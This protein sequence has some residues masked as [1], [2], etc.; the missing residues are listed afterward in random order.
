MSSRAAT[1]RPAG[2]LMRDLSDQSG[3]T[4]LEMALVLPSF[5]LLLFGLFEF[6][7]VLFGYCSA[8]YVSG[9]TARY[10]AVHSSTSLAP[11]TTASL[12][13]LAAA[14]L[15]APSGTTTIT[16]TW[17]PSN[18]AGST[19]N[20]TISIAYPNALAVLSSAQ[21]TVAVTAQRTIMR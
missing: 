8:T 2:W 7:I 18:T 21:V 5:F 6:A 1:P 4:L 15:W 9:A 10:A 16:P 3:G 14:Q 17:T 20:V 11:C 13:T 12:T 19:V